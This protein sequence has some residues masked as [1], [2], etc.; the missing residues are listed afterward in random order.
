MP[1][2]DQRVLTSPMHPVATTCI[3]YISSD[4]FLPGSQRVSL[5]RVIWRLP[6]A[7]KSAQEVPKS[8]PGGP[9]KPK[10]TSLPMLPLLTVRNLWGRGLSGLFP[11][12]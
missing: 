8:P 2:E 5:K 3:L 1:E 7:A 6:R 4:H 12:R 10:T 9:K 11:P